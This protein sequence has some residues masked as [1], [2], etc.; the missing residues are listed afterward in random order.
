MTPGE[1]KIS[2]SKELLTKEQCKIKDVWYCIY[3]TRFWQLLALMTMSNI[4]CNFFGYAS[5]PY[6]ENKVAGEHAPISD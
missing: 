1:K 6:G 5:K 2:E 4:F 3:S